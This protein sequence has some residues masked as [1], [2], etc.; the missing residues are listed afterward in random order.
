MNYSLIIPAGYSINSDSL[1]DAVKIVNSNKFLFEDY[2]KNGSK[3]QAVKT[4]KDLT[5]LGLKESK[6]V[7]DLYWDNKILNIKEDRRE[8][9]E[10]L[11]KNPLIEQIVSKIKKIDEDQ[12]SKN[13]FKLSIDEL[14]SLDEI[15]E[16]EE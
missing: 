13:L 4:L 5:G 15:F 7:M 12:L 16:N 10:R 14:F 6:E 11:A 9:L 8:K 3:L 2:R 1:R